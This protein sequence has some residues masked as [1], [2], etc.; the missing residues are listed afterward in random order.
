MIY[1]FVGKRRITPNGTYV[2]YLHS[3]SAM[4]F[5]QPCRKR[6]GIQREVTI[7]EKMYA[8]IFLHRLLVWIT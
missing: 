2:F 1:I 6:R 3:L 4:P 5:H 8:E 7:K